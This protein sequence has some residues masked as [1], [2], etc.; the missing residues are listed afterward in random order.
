MITTIGAVFRDN[1]SLGAPPER[2]DYQHN[3]TDLEFLMASVDP[4][5]GTAEWD[6][7]KNEVSIESCM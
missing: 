1:S 5:N 6:A 7:S 4:S 2:S 3:Q